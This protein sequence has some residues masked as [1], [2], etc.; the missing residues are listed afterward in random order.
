MIAT[1]KK[2]LVDALKPLSDLPVDELVERRED[3]IVSYGKFKEL[4]P[5]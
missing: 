4:N 1:L 2:A 5:G 3:R